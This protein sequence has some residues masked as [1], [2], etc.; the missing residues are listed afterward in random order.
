MKVYLEGQIATRKYTDKDGV[1]KFSTEIVLQGFNS[2]M[3]LLDRPS[4]G[5]GT[6]GGDN[7]TA[8]AAR[9][10]PPDDSIPF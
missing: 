1:E 4:Q 6:A 2:Q 10:S 9:R 8:P 7:E 5:A 3:T